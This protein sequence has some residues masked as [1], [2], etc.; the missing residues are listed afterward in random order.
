MILV[1]EDKLGITPGYQGHWA[2]ILAAAGMSEANFRR[3]SVWRSPVVKTHMLLRKVGNRKSPGFNPDATPVIYRWL[4][5]MCTQFG[6]EAIIC[7]DV[8][9]LGVVEQDWSIATIDNLRGGVYR[10]KG[11]PFVVTPPITAIN[12]QKKVKDIRA[13]NDGA[14][15]KAEWDDEEH[16][17]EEFFFEPYTIP[18]GRWIIQADIKKLGRVLITDRQKADHVARKNSLSIQ[19]T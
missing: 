1:L 12:S 18:Y 10:F 8:A 11:I 5:S 15:S 7:M 2:S 19:Q 16:E 13:L 6:A 3:I 17:D 4:E 9:M 14:E